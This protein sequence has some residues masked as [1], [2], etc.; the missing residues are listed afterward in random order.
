MPGA[1]NRMIRPRRGVRILSRTG[2]EQLLERFAE[3]F[4]IDPIRNA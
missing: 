3:T 1:H 2:P 4:S